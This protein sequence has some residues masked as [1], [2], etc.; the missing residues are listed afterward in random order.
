MRDLRII[1][2]GTPEFAVPSL[3]ALVNNGFNVVAVI[4]APD[5]PAGR[6]LTLKASAVKETA[7][8]HN[9][10]VLQPVNLKDPEF[11][12]ELKSYNANLQVVVAFR[13]LPENIWSYPEYGTFNLHASLLPDYRGAAPINWAIINGEKETGCTTF[14][15]KHEIDTGN[16]IFFEKE[17]IS[18]DDTIETLYHRLMEKGGALTLKTVQA[19]ASE[20]IKTF[21]QDENS[22]KHA[23]PKIHKETCKIDWNKKADEVR[24]FVRGLSPVPA[25]WTILKEKQLKVFKTTVSETACIGTAPGTMRS[26]GK[27]TIEYATADFWLQ[28]NELQFEGKKRMSTEEFLRGFKI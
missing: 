8:K 11:F 12:E 9:I 16:I 1:F 14:F 23:A 22:A 2:M 21:P 3:E 7:V 5:K 18:D 27:K 13:M 20:E 17:K 25:A 26:D 15:L 28:I 19:I 6:G 24:N 10:P 4:T